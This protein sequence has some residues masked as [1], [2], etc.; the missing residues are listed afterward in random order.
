MEK[1]F[2]RTTTIM[3]NYLND[4]IATGFDYVLPPD[5]ENNFQHDVYDIQI[6]K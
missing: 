2:V 4:L 3:V 5:S 6:A 1:L